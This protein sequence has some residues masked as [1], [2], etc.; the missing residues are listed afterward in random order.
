MIKEKKF[1]KK[2]VQNSLC[3]YTCDSHSYIMDESLRVV[4]ILAVMEMKFHLVFF[5]N[6]SAFRATRIRTR[7]DLQF[8]LYRRS[9]RAGSV[10]LFREEDFVAGNISLLIA[11]ALLYDH[12]K[13]FIDRKKFCRLN[14]L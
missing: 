3:V 10:R 6:S 12:N 5:R 4:V 8:H 13:L 1:A 14:Y 9:R 11:Y 7:N 2:S